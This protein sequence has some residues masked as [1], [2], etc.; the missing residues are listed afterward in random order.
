ML[1]L[2]LI[3]G[4]SDPPVRLAVYKLGVGWNAVYTHLRNPER[5]T[6]VNDREQVDAV[7]EVAIAALS[8]QPGTDP[9]HSVLPALRTSLGADAAGYY[10]HVPYGWTTTVH[11]SP[12]EIWRKLPFTQAPTRVA[13]RLHPGIRHLLATATSAPFAITDIVS[14]RDWRNSELGTLMWPEWGRNHQ[15]LVP[16]PTSGYDHCR[17]VWVLG[18]VDRKFTDHEREL[19]A[20]LQQIL[21]VIT[22]R[23]AAA[24]TGVRQALLGLTRREQSIITMVGRGDDADQIAD[25]LGISRRTVEKHLEHAY[26]KLDVHNK[27]EVARMIRL[28]R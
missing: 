22:R 20:K 24:Q 26:R 6:V 5:L 2:T 12:N 28:V 17:R 11:V 23:R 14:E 27:S 18:R 1:A 16:V 25:Q 10:E 21:V 9:L 13:A 19:C 8:L 3:L 7:L 15:L 4:S